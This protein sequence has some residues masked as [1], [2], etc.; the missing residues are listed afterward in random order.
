MAFLRPTA[1]DAIG[2][3]E[4]RKLTTFRRLLAESLDAVP[5]SHNMMALLE[6]DI[7]EPRKAL[8][9]LQDSGRHV[10]LFAFVVKSIATALAE[11]RGLNSMRSGNRIFE[12]EDIDVNLPVELDS[13]GEK[14]PRQVVIRQAASKSVEEI[15]E[16][17]H[18]AKERFLTA[19]NTGQEDQWALSLMQ[20][21]FILPKFL[22][23][24][25]VRALQANPLNVKR[26]SGTTFITSVAMP[27]VSGFAVPY[28]IGPR[29]VSF[30]L[31][32]VTD[33]PAAVGEEIV[34]REF[35]SMTIAFNHDIVD[36]A[37]A[38]R[39]TRRLKELIESGAVLTTPGLT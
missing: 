20:K 16:E 11:H 12:F 18:A 10:S 3:Y 28:L 26:M 22:L 34:R 17:I 14:T 4:V 25:L 38:A 31:G 5:P 29:A 24:M 35:L 36:G 19:G 15:W 33:K 2:K 21:L 13:S 37:P 7:T 23:S 32:G 9:T 8:R 6:L 39:F 30:A 27:G 1:D